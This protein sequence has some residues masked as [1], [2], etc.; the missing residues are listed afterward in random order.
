M[1]AYKFLDLHFGLRS[2]AERRLKISTL[3]DLNDPFE[4]LPYEVSDRRIRRALHE[5]LNKL[6][7][8]RGILCFSADWRDPVIWAHYSDKHRGLCLG[9]DIPDDQCKKVHYVSKR[10][11]FPQV[12]TL[13]HAEALLFTKYASWKYEQE[14]RIWAQLNTEDNGLYFGDFGEVLKLV[15]VIAGARCDVHESEIVQALGLNIRDVQVV[16][17]R[18]GFK[19]FEIVK[20]KRG[21]NK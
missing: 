3:R 18:A 5:T 10:L 8:N 21:F 4:L 12:P 1:K 17:A 19:E 16:K 20:D 2:I 9:F 7:S 15:K 6:A 11:R 13:E 14:I